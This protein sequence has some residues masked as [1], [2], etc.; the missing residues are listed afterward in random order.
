[1]GAAEGSM[2]DSQSL[3][4]QAVSYSGMEI[5]DEDLQAIL[6]SVALALALSRRRFMC[7]G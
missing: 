4:D 2:R 6:G 7:W 5:R 1:M 3:L